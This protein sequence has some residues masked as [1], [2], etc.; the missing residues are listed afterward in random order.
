MRMVDESSRT[1]F[2]GE[3]LAFHRIVLKR[4]FKGFEGDRTIQI[5]IDGGVDCAHATLTEKRENTEVIEDRSSFEGMPT[6][7]TTHIRAGRDACHIDSGLAGR[8]VFHH[9]IG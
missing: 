9:K 7:R 6:L 1:R 5:D 3:V 4:D 2:L 8:T